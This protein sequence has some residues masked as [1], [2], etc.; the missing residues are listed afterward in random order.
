MY[1]SHGY[2]GLSG[3]LNKGSEFPATEIKLE[4]LLI[5]K[6]IKMIIIHLSLTFEKYKLLLVLI[7]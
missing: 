5:K 7:F 1:V 4:L 6:Y 2:S 3:V